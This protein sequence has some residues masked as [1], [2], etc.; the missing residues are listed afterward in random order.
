M[1][2]TATMISMFALA[3][4]GKATTSASLASQQSAQKCTFHNVVDI[5]SD[6]IIIWGL[7]DCFAGDPQQSCTVKGNEI[8]LKDLDEGVGNVKISYKTNANGT[9]EFLVLWRDGKFAAKGKNVP[10]SYSL[11]DVVGLVYNSD[12]QAGSLPTGCEWKNN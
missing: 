11:R 4:C 5:D 6:D 8:T 3:A 12:G 2:K 1:K 7:R 9:H 10:A